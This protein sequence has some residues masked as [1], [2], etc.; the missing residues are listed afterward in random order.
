MEDYVGK[1]F[2]QIFFFKTFG[3]LYTSN[4]EC[5]TVVLLLELNNR[6]PSVS[7]L[8][9]S[10]CWTLQHFQLGL[11]SPDSNWLRKKGVKSQISCNR[12]E[13]WRGLWQN[14]TSLIFEKRQFQCPFFSSPNYFVRK[15]ATTG[16]FFGSKHNK[17]WFEF[18][19]RR[20]STIL[21]LML[22][23]GLAWISR[24]SD[25]RKTSFKVLNDDHE[26]A[27]ELKVENF[28]KGAKDDAKWSVS[29]QQRNVLDYIPKR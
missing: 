23:L 15:I 18:D 13:K 17:S 4:D 1:N 8:L 28:R 26:A 12:V 19:S 14:T 20:Q 22:S 9:S 3:E 29:S 11:K 24:I 21:T 25:A 7:K 2:L 16:C 6:H 27:N 5:C 10:L